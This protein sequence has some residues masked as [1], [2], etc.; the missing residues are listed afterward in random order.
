MSNSPMRGSSISC[1]LRCVFLDR[2]DMKA[3]NGHAAS[4]V[5]PND[6]TAPL[7]INRRVLGT[8]NGVPTSPAR[9]NEEWLKG[10]GCQELTNICDHYLNLLD[11]T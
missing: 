11:R 6:D 8:G 5:Q 7:R 9:Q 10:P 2:R 4:L 3:R 1:P